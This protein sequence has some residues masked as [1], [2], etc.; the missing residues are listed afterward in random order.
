[1]DN[2]IND[3]L[4]GVDPM[5]MQILAKLPLRLA[6]VETILV[7]NID[8]HQTILLSNQHTKFKDLDIFQIGVQGRTTLGC[9][10]YVRGNAYWGWILD[11]NFERN[12]FNFL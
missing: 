3:V 2:L 5:P 7:G 9:N 12:T 6:I 1:M 8:F 11:G 4:V 10:F